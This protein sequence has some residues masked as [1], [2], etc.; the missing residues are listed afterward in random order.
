[1]HEVY[2]VYEWWKAQFEKETQIVG[3]TVDFNEVPDSQ[4]LEPNM[5]QMEVDDLVDTTSKAGNRMFK[6][7][8]RV[9]EGTGE[10]TLIFDYFTVGSPDDPTAAQQATWNSSPG[11]RRLKQLLKALMIPLAGEVSSMVEAAKGQKFVANVQQ[12]VDAGGGDPKFAGTRK[13]VITAFYPLGS[14]ATGAATPIAGGSPSPTVAKSLT[15]P[16]PYCGEA[17]AKNAYSTHVS[18]RHPDE[19]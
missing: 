15:L 11:A 14:R 19:A 10:G 6:A 4:L 13:N 3:Q 18:S 16:C 8:L 5:Y 1:M 12:K 2:E 17:V 7:T 9:S